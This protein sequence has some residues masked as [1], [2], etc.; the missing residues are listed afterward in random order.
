MVFIFVAIFFVFLD[1]FFLVFSIFWA[2]HTFYLIP[3]LFQCVLD[4]LAK[5]RDGHLSVLTQ[6]K[7]RKSPIAHFMSM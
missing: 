4:F 3:G 6:P 7:F 1:F 2:P 5:I